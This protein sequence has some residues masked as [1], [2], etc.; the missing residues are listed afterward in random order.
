M[1]PVGSPAP[2]FELLHRIG[3]PPIRRSSHQD[4]RPLVILFFPL[5]FSSVCTAEMCAVA[6]DWSAW[7]DL[8]ARIVAISVDSP[9][10]TARFADD[11]GAPFPILS[12]FNKTTAD[13]Y[14]VLNR[15]Y[16]GMDGVANR[17][18]FVVDGQGVVRYAWTDADDSVLPDFV[19]VRK[20]V[21]ELP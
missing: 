21:A 5:A 16:F 19:A 6:E 8:D 3:E 10:V 20:A 17:A 2:D 15:D 7:R 13:A 1:L 12:D 4:G 11:T 9:F 18:A 14:G